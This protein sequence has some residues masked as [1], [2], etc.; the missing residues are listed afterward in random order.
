MKPNTKKTIYLCAAAF[1]LSVLSSFASGIFIISAALM[2][3][4]AGCF[5]LTSMISPS[6]AYLAAI[7]ASVLCA[8][9]LSGSVALA[10]LSLTPF[11]AGIMI[12]RSARAREGRTG[13]TIKCDVVVFLV[14][15]VAAATEYYMANGTLAASAVVGSIGNFFDETEAQIAKMLDEYGVYTAYSSIYDLSAYPK[16][17]FL[18]TIAKEAVFT[19][20]AI[21]PAII[22]TLL[23]VFSYASAACFSL[24]S[25]V[26]KTDLAVPEGKW[27]VLPSAISSW[28]FVVSVFAYF[29]VS[30]VSSITTLSTTSEVIA[31]VLLNV[32]L[33]LIPP[34]FICGIRGLIRRFRNPSQKRRA[35]VSVVIV[36]VLFVLNPLALGPIYAATFIGLEG[37]WDMISFYRFIKFGKEQ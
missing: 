2:C 5:A 14:V 27:R 24:V 13:A 31:F 17:E 18:A 23:N 33:I 16:E 26:S 34:M 9:A 32:V 37:A 4:C 3:A 30:T 25:R 29:V 12:G 8:F 11:L 36:A 1:I 35:I 6:K 7:P 19:F 10:I 28:I 21:S 22:I 20:K 15:L